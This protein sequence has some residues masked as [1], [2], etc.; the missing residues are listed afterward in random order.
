MVD[1]AG[2][3][4]IRMPYY[5]PAASV[6][7]NNADVLSGKEPPSEIKRYPTQPMCRGIDMDLDQ[8]PK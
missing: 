5:Y 8:I 4:T 6:I 2:E 7:S 1:S 3:M